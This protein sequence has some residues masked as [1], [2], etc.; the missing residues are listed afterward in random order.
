[1]EDFKVDIDL[2][3]VWFIKRDGTH[4]KWG[5]FSS[6]LVECEFHIKLDSYT[7]CFSSNIHEF[8]L[9]GEPHI[10]ENDTKVIGALKI[11]KFKNNEENKKQKPLTKPNELLHLFIIYY[12]H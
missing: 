1:M 8:L 12:L 7:S 9:Y 4:S 5:T 10:V 11:Y 2:L 6:W 3:K